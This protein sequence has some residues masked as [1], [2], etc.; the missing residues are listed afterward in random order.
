MKQFTLSIPF[1]GYFDCKNEVPEYD[2]ILSIPF[3]G[4]IENLR[5][6]LTNRNNFQFPLWDTYKSLGL[7]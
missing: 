4:Y 7:S 2:A 6:G 5:L 1:M 3:M